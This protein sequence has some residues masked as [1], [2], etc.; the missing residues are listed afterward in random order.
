MIEGHEVSQFLSYAARRLPQAVIR[1]I[2][3]RIDRHDA[4]HGLDYRPLPY[5]GFHQDLSG[6]AQSNGYEEI[7]REVRD[8]ASEKNWSGH[9]WLP[10]L[11]FQISEGFGTTCLKILNEWIDSGDQSK[12]EGAAALLSDAYAN[13]VFRQQE[14][15]ENLMN[16]ASALSEEC[17]QRVSFSL[18]RSAN[19]EVR[20]SRVGTPAPQDISMRDQAREA[21]SKFVSG[22]PAHRFYQSLVDEAETSIRNGLAR[23]EELLS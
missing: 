20:T 14:F 13:F 18:F 15:V 8:R 6:V 17:Y 12:I 21:A 4:N 5:N 10:K 7:L 11:F 22:S 23:D 19:S 2:L 1:L 16:R 9:F 3:A